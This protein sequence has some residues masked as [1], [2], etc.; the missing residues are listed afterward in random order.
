MSGGLRN[1]EEAAA[2]LA[3]IVRAAEQGNLPF[4]LIGGLA[5]VE[6][7]Y[8]RTTDDMDLL[9]RRA[10][11]VAWVGLFAGIGYRPWQDGGAFMQ[12]ESVA[13]KGPP[14]DIMLTS[15]DTFSQLHAGAVRRTV[16]GVIVP[17]PSLSHLLALKFHAIR[18]TRG[19]RG[20][21]D[22]GDIASLI[23]VNRV[24]VTTPEFRQLC[25]RYGTAELYDYCQRNYGRKN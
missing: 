10:D 19:S 4:L 20:M 17:L 7:G 6:H 24:D 22:M 11:R 8:G 25:D 5:V 12:F 21:K 15:D 3:A 9:I 23:E 14:L 2:V 1:V 13:G 18:H 16:L